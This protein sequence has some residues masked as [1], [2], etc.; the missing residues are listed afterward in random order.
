M[1]HHANRPTKN[2]KACG[3]PFQWRKKWK[4]IWDNV[5][6]CSERCRKNKDQTHPIAPL[7]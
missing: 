3:R 7:D 1:P 6:Y 5:L 2:C 4:G